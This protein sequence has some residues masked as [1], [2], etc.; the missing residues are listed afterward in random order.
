MS[1]IYKRIRDPGHVP[2]HVRN[3]FAERCPSNPPSDEPS[4]APGWHWQTWEG[5]ST[6]DHW[7]REP[8]GR[9]SVAR[10]KI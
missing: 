1:L 9:W 4:P 3:A 8:D 2:T 6:H 10:V 7:L 5:G